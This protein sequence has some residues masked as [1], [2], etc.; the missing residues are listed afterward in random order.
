MENAEWTAPNDVLVPPQPGPILLGSAAV[1]DRDQLNLIWAD[2]GN[3]R[4]LFLSQAHTSAAADP[5]NWRTQILERPAVAMSGPDLVARPAGKLYVV[6]ALDHGA[7]VFQASDDYGRTWPR[8]ET[9]WLV[10]QPGREAATNPRIAVDGRGYLHAA[11]TVNTEER[12]WSGEAV[13]YARSTD[14]GATWQAQEVYR[15]PPGE[16]TAGWISVAVRDGDEIHLAWNRGIAS[17]LGRYH[18]WSPDNGETWS[19]PAPFLPEYVSGQTRWPM[20]V[21]DAGG[22]LH[23]VTV[24][25]GPPSVEGDGES[26]RPRYA[27]WNGSVWSEMTTFP[28]TSAD[29]GTAL[30]IGLGSTLHLVHEAERFQGRLLYNSHLTDAPPVTR[31]QIPDPTPTAGPQPSTAIPS[32]QPTAGET[33]MPAAV[34]PA[35]AP[36]PPPASGSQLASLLPIAPVLALL[37]LVLVWRLRRRD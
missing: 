27:Y 36:P 4:D 11:W 30:A 10:I 22:T 35:L 37:A 2:Q 17:H 1:D 18:S 26:T 3:T 13:F 20:M 5:R 34:G 25:S 21:E 15:S 23:M 29:S 16:S 31:Q 19:A 33:P 32:A 28:E 9:I 8:Y 24:A 6:Y 7:I 14:G 12:G